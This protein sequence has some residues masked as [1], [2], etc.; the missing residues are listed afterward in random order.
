MNL[1]GPEVA[2][3][4]GLNPSMLLQVGIVPRFQQAVRPRLAPASPM[5]VLT[6]LER[7]GPTS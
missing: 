7:E 4:P 3:A 1:D 2:S 5:K 6:L